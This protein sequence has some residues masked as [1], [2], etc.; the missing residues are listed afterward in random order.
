MFFSFPL[1]NVRFSRARYER[2]L[3]AIAELSR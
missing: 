3:E 2:R 1:P